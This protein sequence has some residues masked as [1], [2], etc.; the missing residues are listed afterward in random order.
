ME[1]PRMRVR[2]CSLGRG[3]LTGEYPI[4]RGHGRSFTLGQFSG[5]RPFSVPLPEIRRHLGNIQF[6]PNSALFGIS[7]NPLHGCGRFTALGHIP[8]N[9]SSHQDAPFPTHA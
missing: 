6:I 1:T 7:A 3:R 8:R 2:L 9:L 4:G 5:G